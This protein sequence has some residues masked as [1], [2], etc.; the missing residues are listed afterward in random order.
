MILWPGQ[1]LMMDSEAGDT[2][3]TIISLHHPIYDR[4]RSILT[5]FAEAHALGDGF[6][7]RAGGAVAAFVRQSIST[8]RMVWSSPLWVHI[9]Q[10]TIT[11]GTIS[12]AWH[13]PPCEAWKS[14]ILD[15]TRHISETRLDGNDPCLTTYVCSWHRH[16]IH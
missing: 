7:M 2:A 14:C 1:L 6:T 11:N 5:F 9:R 13:D 8:T 4:Q 3:T 16:M 12:H 15:Y 10:M